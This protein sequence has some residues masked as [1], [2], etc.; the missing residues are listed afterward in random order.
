MVSLKRKHVPKSCLA[1]TVASSSNQIT[2][3]L[4]GLTMCPAR[5]KKNLIE[6]VCELTRQIT[7]SVVFEHIGLRNMVAFPCFPLNQRIKGTL[8]TPTAEEGMSGRTMAATHRGSKKE[9]LFLPCLKR[10]IRS[11]PHGGG[12][13]FN[14][15]YGPQKSLER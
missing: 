8:G 1:A 5:L 14:P 4:F 9:F 6:H 15:Y 10:M 12:L 3:A 11:E 13:V 7:R 2:C